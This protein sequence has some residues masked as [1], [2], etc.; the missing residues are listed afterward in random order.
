MAK[1]QSILGIGFYAVAI[2]VFPK[3]CIAQTPTITVHPEPEFSVDGLAVGMPVAPNSA[4]YHRYVCKPSEQYDQFTRCFESHTEKGVQISRTILHASNLVTWYVNKVV[5]PAY[6]TATDIDAEINRLSSQFSSAPHI[7]RLNETYGYPKAV[8]ATFGGVELHPLTPNDLAILAQGN[9]PRAGILVDFLS[10]FGMSAKAH[11]PVYRLSGTKGFAWI[12]SYNQQGKGSLRFFAADPSQMELGIQHVQEPAQVDVN[13][14]ALSD[15][16][17]RLQN[18]KQQMGGLNQRFL[19]P[20]QAEREHSLTAA[21]AKMSTSADPNQ[22]SNLATKVED[23]TRQVSA[24]TALAEMTLNRR[25]ATQALK[26]KLASEDSKAFPLAISQELND[27]ILRF[28]ALKES[29]TLDEIKSVRV[30]LETA[31]RDIANFKALLDLRRAAGQ[32]IADIQAESGLVMDD[33]IRR[34]LEQRVSNAEKALQSDNFDNAQ[35][36]ISDLINFYNLNSSKIKSN[37]FQA[38]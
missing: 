9:S 28:M 18:A 3:T 10:N 20:E 29:S 35:N 21:I 8:I 27:A 25:Q 17:K 19:S 32:K 12:A 22:I 1:V 33:E 31:E 36:S 38:N 16:Q 23:F 34:G 37:E 30:A 2:A 15:A 4:A 11:L 13:P 14:Q 24:A 26:E 6:F 5:S 7:Y